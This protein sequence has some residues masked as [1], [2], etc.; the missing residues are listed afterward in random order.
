MKKLLTL[1]L[2]FIVS[3][4]SA[5]QADLMAGPK[6]SSSPVVLG[7]PVLTGT[8]TVISATPFPSTTPVFVA[9]QISSTP[10]M[11]TPVLGAASSSAT[12]N[13]TPSGL[14]KP[15]ALGVA[16]TPALS[17]V[18]AE[19]L[20][21]QIDG[22]MVPSVSSSAASVFGTG[23]GFDAR[24]SFAADDV[25]SIG[26]ESGYYSFGVNVKNTSLPSNATSSLTHVPL[27]IAMQVNLGDSGG[28]IQPYFV[29]AGGLAIDA[30]TL[31]GAAF[32][33]GVVSSWTNFEFDPT[34]GVG[35]PLDRNTTLF[36]QGKWM[37]DFGDN[38]SSNA[39]SADAPIMF[40][41]IQAGVNFSL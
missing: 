30:Y 24:F 17:N 28:F 31:T 33:P 18:V 9:T 3:N 25:F 20:V 37:M 38:S 22:G 13:G 1:M 29:L 7:T 41:P 2:L 14:P 19:H 34:L 21:F 15:P 32:A 6:V 35:F 8:A 40:V 4:V 11:G 39:E 16:A 23:F 10:I 36:V 5:Q 27:L 26:L 12:P